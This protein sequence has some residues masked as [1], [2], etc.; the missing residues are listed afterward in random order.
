MSATWSKDE[1][2]KK[3]HRVLLG[4]GVAGLLVGGSML[5]LS[6]LIRPAPPQP[7]SSTPEQTVEQ[8]VKAGRDDREQY[9]RQ[10]RVPDSNT[11]ILTLL[12]NPNVSQEQRRKLMENVLPV[13]GPVID[14]RLDEFERLS[15]AERTARLDGIIDRMQQIR[16]NNPGTLSS[17][18]RLNLILQYLDPHTRARFRKHLPALKAR[19]KKRGISTALPF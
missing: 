17:T 14:Q 19:M 11:P 8:F 7:Q 6:R 18:E 12:F 10:I 2:M 13:V 16:G 15:V 3:S 5:V 9:I 4:C 1:N